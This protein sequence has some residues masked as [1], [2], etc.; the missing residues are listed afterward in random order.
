MNKN[1]DL[2]IFLQK[3]RAKHKYLALYSK[4]YIN[5]I[6]L[7]ERISWHLLKLIKWNLLKIGPLVERIHVLR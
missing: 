6:S 7:I 5:W 1:G 4:I 3:N 2:A